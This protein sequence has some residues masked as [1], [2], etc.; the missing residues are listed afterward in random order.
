MMP[1]RGNNEEDIMN[2]IIGYLKALSKSRTIQGIV[3]TA[4]GAGVNY[5]RTHVSMEALPVVDSVLAYV[6]GLLQAAGLGWAAYGR[7]NAAGPIF[8]E[9]TDKPAAFDGTGGDLPK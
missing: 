6:A 7:V 4:I 3:A 8:P 2:K 9:T 5:V 1:L